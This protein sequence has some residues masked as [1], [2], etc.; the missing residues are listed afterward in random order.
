MKSAWLA[1][2]AA[3]P[4]LDHK[5]ALQEVCLETDR[6]LRKY[7]PPLLSLHEATSSGEEHNNMKEFCMQQ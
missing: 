1:Y 2:F 3:Q 7:G 4:K 6:Y 5:E